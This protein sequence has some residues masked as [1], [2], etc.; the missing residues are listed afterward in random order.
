MDNYS[1]DNTR[2]VV[3]TCKDNRIKY[4]RFRNKG[5]I[6]ASRNYGVS[7]S[8]GEVIAFLDSDDE[9]VKDKLKKQVKHLFCEGISCVCSNY[10]PIGDV[11]LGKNHLKFRE[12]ES[13][14]DFS[15]NQIVLNNPVIN[16]SAMILRDTYIKLDGLD[17]NPDFIAI[18]DWDLWLRASKMGNIRVFT[19]DSRQ[20]GKKNRK[21]SCSTR[22]FSKL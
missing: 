11:S 2:Q 13:L 3:L 15:Y 10:S 6:A 18:E 16:S 5:I 14:Q 7:Q 22:L 1:E 12:G 21:T 4:F 8:Q 19:H 9:W 17:E 20:N